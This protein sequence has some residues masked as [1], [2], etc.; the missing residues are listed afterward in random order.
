VPADRTSDVAP[1]LAQAGCDATRIG[2]VVAGSGVRVLDAHGNE[3][4][5]PQAGWEHFSQ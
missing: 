4:A 5:T 3:L 2:R 1:A